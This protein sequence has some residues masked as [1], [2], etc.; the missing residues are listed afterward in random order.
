MTWRFRAGLCCG[1]MRTFNGA[2]AYHLL[3]LTFRRLPAARN[4]LGF[5]VLRTCL[6]WAGWGWLRMMTGRQFLSALVLMLLML[7][8]RQKLKAEDRPEPQSQDAAPQPNAAA[9]PP[10]SPQK[11]SPQSPE[12]G[13][14]ATIIDAKRIE[15]V[16][17][18]NVLSTSGEN[19]GRIVDI[20][21]DRSGQ[22]RAAVIDFGGFLGVGSRKIAVDWSALHFDLKGDS[23]VITVD[24]T[25]ERLRIAPEV[26]QGEPVVIIGSR[27]S[28]SQ[29]AG[30]YS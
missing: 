14:A 30:S 2:K 13:T 1:T 3:S 18:R 29:Q 26:K 6:G 19:I 15:S 21:A 24:L 20:L 16:L 27:I 28:K 9:P 8:G 4:K 22:V 10:A 7:D 25:R 12:V 23:I 17:G 5:E 11:P